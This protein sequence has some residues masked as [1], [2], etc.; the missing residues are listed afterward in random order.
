MR[1]LVF[2]ILILF[3]LNGCASGKFS[4]YEGIAKFSI[5]FDFPDMERQE[6]RRKKMLE[7]MEKLK[8]EATQN[9]EETLSF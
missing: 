8:W 3:L 5:P 6:L 9:D 1:L 7:E 2:E 4:V